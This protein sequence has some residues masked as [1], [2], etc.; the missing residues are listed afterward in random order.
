MS[1]TMEERRGLAAGRR[2]RSPN[3]CYTGGCFIARFAAWPPR[4][5][6]LTEILIESETTPSQRVPHHRR[7]NSFF[8]YTR[9]RAFPTIPSSFGRTFGEWGG[10]R[11][12]KSRGEGRTGSWPRHCIPSAKKK[13]GAYI[14]SVYKRDGKADEKRGGDETRQGRERSEGWFMN[15]AYGEKC[16]ATALRRFFSLSLSLS[17]SLIP[18]R[19]LRNDSCVTMPLVY[20]RIVSG[21]RTIVRK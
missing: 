18:S 5:T 20:I 2:R 11:M 9:F 8:V 13:T 6:R 12:R 3:R 16:I 10:P 19:R 15:I 21:R 1:P 17:L 4:V 14:L 7:T